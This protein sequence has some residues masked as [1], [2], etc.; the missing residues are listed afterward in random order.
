M[1]FGISI[2]FHFNSQLKQIKGHE[3]ESNDIST[4]WLLDIEKC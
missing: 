4:D 1:A 3:N 2:M